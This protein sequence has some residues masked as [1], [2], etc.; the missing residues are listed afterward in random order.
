M[1]VTAFKCP[2][3]GA[4]LTFSSEAQK[5]S[6]EYCGTELDVEAVSELSRNEQSSDDMNWST[7]SETTVGLEGDICTYTCGSCGA[8]ITGDRSLGATTC[9]YC[10]SPF[11]VNDKFDGMLRPDYVIPF[12][13]DKDKAIAQFK[14]F[15]KKRPLLPGNFMSSHRIESVQGMYVPYWLFDCGAKAHFR[16]RAHRVAHWT[17]GDYDVTRTDH[18]MLVRDGS[19]EFDHVPVD[20]TSKLQREITE[21]IE[22]F[23]PSGA[24]AFN[25]AYLSGYLADK[26]D[27]SAE[28]SRPR[29]DERIKESVEYAFRQTADT[30]MGVMVENSNIS[31]ENGQIHYALMPM[32]LMTAKYDGKLYT[33]A[34]NGQTGRFVGELPISW[35]RF[36]GMFAAVSAVS[37]VL[38]AIILGFLGV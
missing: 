5:M 30:Y 18:F 13:V 4:E 25:P 23:D 27:V 19:M 34:M 35:A 6:C 22:P 15:C 38:L 24:T 9:P 28:D 10:D 31:L 16:F 37:A 3:C 2:C 8:E 20:G 7:A 11:V 14:E 33:F 21:A 12:K 26:Y 17:E 36:W 29:A 32:W 1:S